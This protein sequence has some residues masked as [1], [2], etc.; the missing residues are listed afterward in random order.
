[1]LVFRIS[2]SKYAQELS[3]S[4]IA[5]R[6]NKE[7]QYVIYTSESRSLA[8]LELLVHRSGLNFNADYK[9]I[10]IE[11]KI[12]DSEIETISLKD[13]PLNW[14]S[15][16]AYALLQE[17]GT[18]WYEAKKNLILKIPSVIIP[19]E[20]NFVINT[21]HPDFPNKVKIVSI[22]EYFWDERLL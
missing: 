10:V 17:I 19:Q 6:W 21:K 4:G 13:L 20:N 2:R 12:N 16:E 8:S 18:N 11:L 1:M 15:L 22:D 5:N 3:A 9:L 14:K 7:G